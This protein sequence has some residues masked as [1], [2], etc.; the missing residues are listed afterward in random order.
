MALTYQE[1]GTQGTLTLDGDLT[2]AQAEELRMLLIKSIINVDELTLEF[3]DVRDV[4]L[5]CLQLLC[6]V[7]RSAVRMNKR[8]AF[9]GS[10]PEAF[11]KVMRDA[12]YVRSMG[13]HLDCFGSC[14][15][16]KR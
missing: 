10:R 13:C 3:G 14:L 12:G 1:S 9:S 7:H 2:L 11:D 15:W 4:D 8:V 16:V 5:S 6:S